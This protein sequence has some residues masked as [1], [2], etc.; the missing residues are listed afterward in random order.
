MLVKGGDSRSASGNNLVERNMIGG[1]MKTTSTLAL[2][3]AAGLVFGGA[4]V[5]YAGDAKKADE[6]LLDRWNNS[7]APFSLGGITIYGTVDAGYSSLT[8]GAPPSGLAPTTEPFFIG[9]YN[10]Q[11]WSG[12]VS[13]PLEQSKLGIKGTEKIIDDLSFVFKAETGFNPLNGHLVDGVGSVA[14]ANGG[15]QGLVDF[16]N[17]SSRAGQIFQGALWGGLSHKTLGDLTFGRQNALLA[18]VIGG[19]DPMGNSYA[20]GL[21]GFSGTLGGGG[22]DTEDY[23]LDN[24]LKYANKIGDKDKGGAFRFAGEYQFPTV[25]DGGQAY[26]G[27]VGVDYKGLSVDAAYLNKTG[28]ESAGPAGA[29]LPANQVKITLSDNQAWA[30]TAKYDGGKDNYKLF[31]GYEN[32]SQGNSSNPEGLGFGSPV[33]G[34]YTMAASSTNSNFFTNKVQQMWWVGGK[35]NFMKNLSGTVAYYH[36]DQ[37]DFLTGAGGASGTCG[38][39]ITV[40]ANGVAPN[41]SP[42]SNCAGSESATSF[43]LDYQATKRLDVYGGVMYSQA[44][45]GYTN[46]FLDTNAANT[47]VTVGSRVK[48]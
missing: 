6:T 42:S 35:Y 17:D 28:G 29:G 47:T 43:L 13:S 5:A 27:S 16:P 37:N 14:L 33:I 3:A 34:G 10:N 36:V 20:F 8:N 2:L 4:S 46:N 18:D 38:T 12:W 1:L 45:G 15:V 25:E 22:G 9:K 32:I 7:D 26:A 44:S 11:S 40:K 41:T 24:S 23:R 39:A 21:I 30:I 19:A 31:A 48:F